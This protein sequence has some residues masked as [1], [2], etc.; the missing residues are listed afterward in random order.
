[1]KRCCPGCRARTSWTD[2]GLV[3][4]APQCGLWAVGKKTGPNPTDRG[5]PGSKHHVLTEA[6]GIPPSAVLTGTNRHDVTQLL[7]LVDAVPPVRG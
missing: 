6:N 4:T 2:R 3:R 5:K 7:H 1:M